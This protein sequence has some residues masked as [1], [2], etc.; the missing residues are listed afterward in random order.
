MSKWYEI[1]FELSNGTKF[2]VV[3]N[4]AGKGNINTITAAFNCW[5]VRTDEYTQQSFIDYVNS[6]NAGYVAM[7]RKQYDKMQRN[8]FRGDY[9]N[10]MLS[11]HEN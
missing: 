2:S 8:S 4:I 9:K 1:F 6:K 5:L 3:H 10:K 11:R 7:T